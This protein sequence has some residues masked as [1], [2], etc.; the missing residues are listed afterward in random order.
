[1]RSS[2]T[3]VASAAAVTVGR[4]SSPAPT[5]D[6]VDAPRAYQELLLGLL[7]GDDPAAVQGETPA[8][9]RQLVTEAGPEL[10]TTPEPGEWSVLGCIAHLV[11]AEVVMSGRYRWI[12]AQDRPPLTG[13]DQ[14]AWVARLHRPDEPVEGLI[15]LFTPLRHANLELWRSSDESQRARVGMHAERGPE[16]YD[17]CFRMIAG[18]DR[19]H[20][21][22][23]R[24][25]LAAARR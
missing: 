21:A 22:Q 12:L 24:R 14:D 6:P 4:M 10:R 7:G 5:P 17:L 15:G 23:A 19:F 20:L 13:Y 16:S 18:H 2:L 3:T 11:D 9:L 25:A 1:M 8:A